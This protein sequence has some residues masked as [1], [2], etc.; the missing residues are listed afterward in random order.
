MEHDD[1]EDELNLA[2]SHR[3]GEQLVPMSERKWPWPLVAL[4]LVVLFWSAVVLAI[5]ACHPSV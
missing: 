2:Q 5:R 4:G 3:F 1:D